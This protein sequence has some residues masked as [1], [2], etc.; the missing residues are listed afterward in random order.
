M[1]TIETVDDMSVVREFFLEY[2]AALG[3]DLS[4][5]HFDEEVA[6]L[7]GDYDPILIA[8]CGTGFPAGPPGT[9]SKACPTPGIAG[10]IAMRR[11]DE[12]TCEMKRLYV[13]PAARGHG[14]GRKL[15]NELI[16]IARSRG[17]ERMRLDTLPS[18]HEAM[19]LYESLGF[20]DIEPY[21]YNPVAGSRFL[22]LRLQ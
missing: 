8:S 7:P 16:A 11:I 13:R 19:L 3:V 10:C 14:V 12:Q 17:F 18:M 22:E 4:F 2:A 21:R 6:S 9:G 20:R 15:A 5:Q 1:I